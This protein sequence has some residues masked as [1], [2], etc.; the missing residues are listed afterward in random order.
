MRFFFFSTDVMANNI[1]LL[2]ITAPVTAVQTPYFYFI[3]VCV[4]NGCTNIIPIVRFPKAIEVN[5][6]KT[7]KKITDFMIV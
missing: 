5:L 6:P 7:P 3:Y 4:A 1:L 2:P